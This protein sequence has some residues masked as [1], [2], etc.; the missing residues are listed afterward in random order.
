LAQAS[1]LV[2][3]STV[4][5]ATGTLTVSALDG[6]ITQVAAKS[7]DVTGTTSLTADNGVSG[8][9]DVKYGITLAQA[10]DSFG[11]TVTADGSAITLKDAA[12]LTAILDSSGATSLTSAGALNVSGTVGTKLRTTTT[13][14]NSATTFGATTVG[15]SLKVT[16]TGA[17][18]E[19]SPNI[20]TVDG[21]GTTT[22]PN[23]K[24]CVNGTC[25]VE[26]PA[27]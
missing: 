14:T 1:K 23:S 3:R 9:G 22:A 13:G 20:L 12:G 15:K 25:D 5:T 24:V 8:A 4:M 27:P 6:S 18:T 17:V 26:I 10:G 11:G 2:F 19:S 7:V 16:N 21:A